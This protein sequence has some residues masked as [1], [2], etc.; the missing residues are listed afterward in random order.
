MPVTGPITIRLWGIVNPNKLDITRTGAFGF[1][2]MEDDNVI[3]GNFQIT[4]IIPL[5]APGS[6]ICFATLLK[7]NR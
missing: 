7:A 3:E 5:L 1:A 4:G 2:L 6:F